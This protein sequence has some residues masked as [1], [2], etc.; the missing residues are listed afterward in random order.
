MNITVIG[1]GNMGS[2]LAGIISRSG[3]NVT[4]TGKELD[5]VQEAAAK[6]GNNIKVAPQ[7]EAAENADIVISATPYPSQVDALSSVGNLDGKIVIDISNPLKE[8]MSGLSIG[9]TTSAAEEISK[10]LPGVKVVKAFNTVLAQ[11]FSEGN[12]FG[13]QKVQVLIA[14]DDAEAKGKVKSFVESLGFDGLDAGPLSNA[15]NLEPIGMQNIYFA[16][17]AGKG[18]GIAPA[19]ISRK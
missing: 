12:D 16:Y 7:A 2:G 3:H 15:R 8:D 10:A 5:K 13:S 6:I 11:I 14:G 18:T 19:W 1:S 17:M 4:L 9:F